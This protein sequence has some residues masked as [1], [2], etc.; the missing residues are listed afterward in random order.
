[1]NSK[2]SKGFRIDRATFERLQHDQEDAGRI[3][4]N[5]VIDPKTASEGWAPK[6]G[7]A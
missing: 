2:K 5:W 3:M 6:K 7:R 1:M 4:H